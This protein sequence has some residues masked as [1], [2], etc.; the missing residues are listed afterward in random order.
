MYKRQVQ[1][2]VL[3][4]TG[5]IRILDSGTQA[6]GIYKEKTIT[7]TGTS[8]DISIFA[9]SITNGGNIH[10]MTGGSA[11]KRLT[12]DSSGNATFAGTVSSDRL[13]YN[14]G[15]YSYLS[16]TA[17]GATTILGHNVRAHATV[18]NRA[19]TVNGSWHG[20]AIAMYYDR[21]ISFYTTDSVSYTHLTLPTIL[22]V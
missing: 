10:F 12:L 8:N 4:S 21:G 18:N 2:S 16:Q 6:G 22:R 14:A 15:N 19:D 9:E 11:T 13:G 7:G 1:G 5:Y 20:H 17:S 3:D